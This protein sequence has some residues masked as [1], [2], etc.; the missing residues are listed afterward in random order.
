MKMFFYLLN[1][2]YISY[3]VLSSFIYVYQ[4]LLGVSH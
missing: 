3:V 4:V 1:M 2:Y